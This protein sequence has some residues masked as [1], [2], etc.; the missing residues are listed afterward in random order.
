MGFILG[1]FL[2]LPWLDSPKAEAETATPVIIECL[3]R[4]ES[5]A[6]CRTE[7][8]VAA[9][10]LEETVSEED[11]TVEALRRTDHED[12]DDC[13]YQLEVSCDEGWGCR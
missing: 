6:E 12:G 3:S 7:E 2:V 5:T 8:D 9:D 1:A 10:Y 11:C 13:C 4:D